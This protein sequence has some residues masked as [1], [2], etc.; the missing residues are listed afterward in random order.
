MQTTACQVL[1]ASQPQMIYDR[2][3]LCTI[4][5]G[6]RL[7]ALAHHTRPARL[8]STRRRPSGQRCKCWMQH[9][10][11][12]TGSDR[13]AGLHVASVADR[14]S[15]VFAV[16][17]SD[18]LA[19]SAPWA[20]D[21]TQPARHRDTYHRSSAAL[22]GDARGDQT[23]VT[24]AVTTAGKSCR[25]RPCP[26]G[27]R[28]SAGGSVL[29]QRQSRARSQRLPASADRHH[30]MSDLLRARARRVVAAAS[31][32]RLAAPKLRRRLR[33]RRP[34]ALAPGLPMQ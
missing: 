31:R 32:R 30:K 28:R 33:T 21:R 1:W 19:A 26:P 27:P 15:G 20:L 3:H 5:I 4:G 18:P 14:R 7:L 24:A 16:G 13:I 12:M 34:V 22:S 2:Q 8:K 10:T 11:R 23:P 9:S 6:M 17:A 29:P 25:N